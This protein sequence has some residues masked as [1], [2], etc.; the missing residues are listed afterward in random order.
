MKYNIL[1]TSFSAGELGETL[2]AREDIA[3]YKEGCSK[4][5]NALL[6]QGGGVR[7]RPSTML[8]GSDI[9][10]T[11][12][13]AA[14]LPFTGRDGTPYMVRIQ[15]SFAAAIISIYDSNMVAQT[16][17]GGY[18]SSMLE[19][20]TD[21]SGFH[22]EQLEDTM[23]V[24]HNSGRLS[25]I[26]IKEIATGFGVVELTNL[27]QAT[28]YIGRMYQP[29]YKLYNTDAPSFSLSTTGQISPASPGTVQIS[30]IAVTVT[31]STA[32]FTTTLVDAWIGRY[33]KIT[34]GSYEGVLRIDARTDDTHVTGVILV[35]F[36]ATT[37]TTEWSLSEWG[38]VDALASF[39]KSVASYQE[40]WIFG[41]SPE[42]IG[43]LWASNNIKSQTPGTINFMQTQFIQDAG[44]TDTSKL[45]YYDG[46]KAASPFD[47]GISG[48]GIKWL[49]VNTDLL[50]GTG[51]SEYVI[52][53]AEGGFSETSRQLRKLSGYGA[54]NMPPIF[55][56]DSIIYAG[57][58]GKLIRYMKYSKY[59]YQN[60]NL[61]LLNPEIVDTSSSLDSYPNSYLYTSKYLGGCFDPL[62]STVWLYNYHGRLVSFLLDETS[63]TVGW[64]RHK[65]S[66]VTTQTVESLCILDNHLHIA[67]YSYVSATER[68][69]D[70][71]RMQDLTRTDM[72]PD[73]RIFLDR[74]YYD[75]SGSATITDTDYAN[76]ADVTVHYQV[77]G[78]TWITEVV[79]A[80]ASGEMV[81]AQT[82]IIAYY[83]FDFDS[84]I[85]TLPLETG[86]KAGVSRGSLTRVDRLVFILW[87][88]RALQ[89]GT[90]YDMYTHIV[91][92]ADQSKDL[93]VHAPHQTDRNAIIKIESSGV[94][95]MNILGLSIRGNL[96]ED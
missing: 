1:K 8:I 3:Q 94:Y 36:N 55:A 12:K 77:A 90:E 66:W 91:A 40:R 22:Y 43:T 89:V 60:L 95:D 82:P 45:G 7:R 51:N 5:E 68:A 14:I 73:T 75:L 18:P 48:S 80:N 44:S 11:R 70:I 69:Q 59:E 33:L 9:S 88:T 30:P 6:M 92:L 31:A 27:E 46:K 87:R 49:A 19:Y 35:S 74:Y 76:L 96:E 71:L 86:A 58:G 10:T 20:I 61:S 23:I 57:A 2:Q 72:I 15:V 41:G 52:T 47:M 4:T 17:Y 84:K 85:W 16:I 42:K 24:V 62:T 64:S 56:G 83:G 25:P 13:P 53:G 29:P 32:I 38:G 67:N 79:D 34:H 50:I 65:S 28:S 81:I 63:K 21:V 54:S 78:G 26:V 39:P 37:A 93:V